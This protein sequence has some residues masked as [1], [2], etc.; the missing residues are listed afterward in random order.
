MATTS[1]SSWGIKPCNEFKLLLDN[2]DVR[3]WEFN[4]P[5]HG[6][7]PI[8]TH[9]ISKIVVYPLSSGTKITFVDGRNNEVGNY[10]QETGNMTTWH[11]EDDRMICDQSNNSTLKTKALRNDS[12]NSFKELV[13]EIKK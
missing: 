11:V 10:C 7:T 6:Q 12:S 8:F 5:A 3:V 2:E 1:I 13:I 9:E 4:I